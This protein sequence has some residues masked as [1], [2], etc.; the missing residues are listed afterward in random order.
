M[1]NQTL[2]DSR[3]K[4]CGDAKPQLS[5]WDNSFGKGRSYNL[6]RP[7]EVMRPR[8][9]L[10]LI[11]GGGGNRAAFTV[12][13]SLDSSHTFFLPLE[14][15]LSALSG[16]YSL[17]DQLLSSS[18]DTFFKGQVL[19]GHQFSHMTETLPGTPKDSVVQCLKAKHLGDNLQ[20][21]QTTDT[22]TIVNPC[23]A[24]YFPSTPCKP[25]LS[26]TQRSHFT[27]SM[28]VLFISHFQTIN[29]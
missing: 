2:T 24:S 6:D 27:G 15:C 29:S 20:R 26:M 1:T 12:Q 16:R 11:L 19:S 5:C 8:K 28:N 21:Q 4:A 13:I 18:H 17:N 9:T 3:R 7:S 10:Y 22:I 23:P 14:I 25:M